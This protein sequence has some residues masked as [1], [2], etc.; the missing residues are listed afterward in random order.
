[1]KVAAV[2]MVSGPRWADNLAQARQGV[3]QAAQ[4]GAQLVVLPEYFC[5]MGHRDADKL[6]LLAQLD[7]LERL[8]SVSRHMLAS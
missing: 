1:M 3:T 4:A 8:E 7:P 2:Q 6:A 5:F